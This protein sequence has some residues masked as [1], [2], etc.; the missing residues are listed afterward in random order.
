[1]KEYLATYT[2]ETDTL[3]YRLL[4]RDLKAALY[5]AAE[6]TPDGYTL[7]GCVFLPDW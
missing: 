3:Q 1:M 4:A 5:A 7:K 2:G 6:L